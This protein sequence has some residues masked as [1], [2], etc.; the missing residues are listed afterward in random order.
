MF[1][2]WGNYFFLLGS[3]AAGLIGL[4]FVVV[5]LTRGG[6]HQKAERGQRLFMTPTVF[7]LASVLT[8]SALCLLPRVSPGTHR[9]LLLAGSLYGLGYALVITAQLVHAGRGGAPHWSDAWCY[10]VAPVVAY[11][12]IAAS[13]FA[14]GG[15]R[16]G[17]CTALALSLL[18]LLL[19]A[20]R[21]AW[22]LVTWIAPRRERTPEP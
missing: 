1:E 19:V 12:A 21:N 10:A 20:V 3:A 13:A 6:D 4:M 11:G 7:H 2:G 15:A 17:A 8:F 9:L 5:T 22:D 16:E 18:A 14:L